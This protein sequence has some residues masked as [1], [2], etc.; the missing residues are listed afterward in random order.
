MTV[1]T[2]NLKR[3]RVA[4][5]MTQEQAAEAL[6]VSTQTVSRWECNTTLPDVTVLPK[7]AALYC[8]TID[9]LYKETSTAYDNYAQRLGSVFEASHKPE[10]FMQAYVEYQK[11][12]KSGKYTTEDLRLYGILYQQMMQVCMEKAAEVFDR[13]IKAGPAE[14]P[15][16]YWAV[17]RQ[18]VYFI[19][20]I[21][22]N[23]ENIDTFLP[24]VKA[25]SNDLNE[26][27]CLIQAYSFGGDYN[28][29]W[30]W[31]QKAE[32][33]FPESAMLHIYAGDLLR[34]MKRI[35]EAFPHW[36]RALEM[37][38]DWLAAAHSMASCYEE[39]G[40]YKNA[41]VVYTQI[42]DNLE[43]RGFETEVNFPRSLAEKCREKIST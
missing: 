5:N 3:L 38:P 10:D 25:G 9:D 16:V 40:D 36:K 29:A 15:E 18:K 23:Q 1:F 37:E 30:E 11:L 21:G 19:W 31:V 22:R 35:D 17:R 7:I 27:I 14:D 24:L 39:I 33:T 13:V 4:K 41:C 32:V 8:V 43:Q 12:L 2:K 42:A 6:G 20:K 26:W 34:D 28:T